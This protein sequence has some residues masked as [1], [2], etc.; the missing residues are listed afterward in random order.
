M[1]EEAAQSLGALV[2][3]RGGTALTTPAEIAESIRRH[4][5]A[6]HAQRTRERYAACWRQYQA[7]CEERDFPSLVRPLGRRTRGEDQD[8]YDAR[9][10][11]HDRA[12]TTALGAVAAYLTWLADGKG[13]G[14]PMALSSIMQA[15]AAI[16]L[17]QREARCG[18]DYEDPAFRALL[19]GIR[20]TVS[21]ARTIRRVRG[22]SAEDLSDLLDRMGKEVDDVRDAAILATLWAGCRRRSEL[23]GLDWMSKGSSPGATGYMTID[24]KGVHLHLMVSKT[25]QEGEAEY[26]QLPRQHVPKSVAAVEAWIKM[27]KPEPGEPIFRSLCSPGRPVAHDKARRSGYAGITWEDRASRKTPW[28]VRRRDRSELGYAATVAAA[29]K[30]LEAAGEVP[31]SLTDPSRLITPR[32]L[33][34]ETVARVVKKRMRW[35]IKKRFPRMPAAE[36]DALVREYSGHSGR[37]GAITDAKERGID[38]VDI[39]RQSGHVPGSKM[40]GVYTRPV[41]AEK[42]SPLR[43]V[44]SGL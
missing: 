6:A 34:G 13:A 26:Y 31:L 8:A 15:L 43:G 17:H 7:Y 3:T 38:D 2:P 42:R 22:I 23:C 18:L 5:E 32:R 28:R 16:K 21:S 9:V 10:L 1:E 4:T 19:K 39:A 27:L 11:A 41:D 30:V 40:I 14:R 12:R 44:R 35:L 20:R 33:L 36:I 29:L 25:H 37:V 24:A